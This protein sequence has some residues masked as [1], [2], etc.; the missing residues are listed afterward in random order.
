MSAFKT[1]AIIE[2]T[3][4]VDADCHTPPHSACVESTRLFEARAAATRLVC[5]E[6]AV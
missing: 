2:A 5:H 1:T 4:S 3:C 6:G